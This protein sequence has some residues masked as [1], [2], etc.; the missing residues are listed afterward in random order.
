[1]WP[2]RPAPPDG[3][4]EAGEGKHTHCSTFVASAAMHAGIYILRPPEHPQT[5]LANAQ[6]EWLGT[7]G[8]RQ[9]WR[10]LPDAVAAQA[11]ANGGSFV[12]AAYRNHK[13]DKPGH[14]VIIRPAAKSRSQLMAEGPDVTQA[15]GSNYRVTSLKQGFAGH[16]HAFPDHEIVYFAHPVDPSQLR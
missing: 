11:E 2:G 4:P 3:G 1:M 14:I 16:P 5:L 6:Y 8:L 12:V 9:G 7:E 15:G 10:S 13:D